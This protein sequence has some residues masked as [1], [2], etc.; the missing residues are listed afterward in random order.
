MFV[1]IATLLLLS[2]SHHSFRLPCSSYRS[3]YLP[4]NEDGTLLLRLRICWGLC[5]SR[6]PLFQAGNLA[7]AT[8]LLLNSLRV[9]VYLMYIYI[10]TQACVMVSQDCS[11]LLRDYFT[12]WNAVEAQLHG[13]SILYSNQQKLRPGGN[14]EFGTCFGLS[15]AEDAMSSTLTSY[16]AIILE[17]TVRGDTRYHLQ[18]VMEAQQWNLNFP[19]YP[20]PKTRCGPGLGLYVR[21]SDG[22]V[23]LAEPSNKG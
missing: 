23:L 14:L 11:R 6:G 15:G 1:L 3:S 21:G 22:R 8:R 9:F 5:G 4:P 17:F 16:A 12:F 13:E 10:Y 2:S 19:K 18:H 20:Y 7:G